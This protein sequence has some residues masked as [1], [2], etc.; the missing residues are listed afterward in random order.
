MSDDIKTWIAEGKETKADFLIVVCD[1]F[2]WENYP[3]YASIKTVKNEIAAHNGKNMQTIMEVYDLHRR[4]H[5]IIET[6]TGLRVR[7]DKD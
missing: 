4:K 7:D 3:V 6:S 5:N 2:S 1:T